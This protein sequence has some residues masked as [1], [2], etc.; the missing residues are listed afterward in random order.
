MQNLLI[1]DEASEGL[2][3]IILEE[4]RKQMNL[5]KERGLT[6][7]IV[8]Q[9]VGFALSLA[10]RIYVLGARGTIVWE[11]TPTDFRKSPELQHQYLGV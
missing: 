1:M 10:D 2:A 5:L 7:L 4:I 3:P 9:N 6:T 8:E 11:T